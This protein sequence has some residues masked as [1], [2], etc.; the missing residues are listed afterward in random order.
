MSFLDNLENNLKSLE[1]N[2]PGGLDESR[3]RDSERER[4]IASA[5]W[6]EKL[7]DGAFTK[8]LMGLATR[9]GF[10]RRLKVYI[11][12][13]GTTLRFEAGDN[14]M[15][16]RPGPKGIT[17]HFIEGGEETSHT[18]LDLGGDPQKL[19]T[20]WMVMVD[21]RRKFLAENAPPPVEEFDE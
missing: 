16:L 18:N 1:A 8:T 15:E 5:P 11:V 10:S 9:A 6:A 14:K 2:E 7:R 3:R 21:A 17:A 4:S 13:L 19:V 12:W 20:K